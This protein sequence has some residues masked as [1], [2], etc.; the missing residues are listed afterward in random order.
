MYARSCAQ[1]LKDH[2]NVLSESNDLLF[3]P[4]GKT[5]R[6]IGTKFQTEPMQFSYFYGIYIAVKTTGL[7]LYR[8]RLY[9]TTT[10]RIFLFR[11]SVV[12]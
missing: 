7:L 12:C 1:V 4:T 8:L 9:E 5:L 6:T 2:V 11:S 3:R 10:V